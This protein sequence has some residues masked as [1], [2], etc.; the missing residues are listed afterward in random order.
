MIHPYSPGPSFA[1]I[2]SNSA[3]DLM[4]Q[5]ASITIPTT[6]T[7]L[8][9]PVV[10]VQRGNISYDNTTGI[11][12][13]NQ[14]QIWFHNFLVNTHAQNNRT[15]YAYA[16]INTGSGWV[17]S[18][19][20]GRIEPITANTDGQVPFHSNNYFAAGT[21]LRFWWY[22]SGASVTATSTDLP[23]LPAGTVTTPAVRIMYTGVN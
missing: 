19:W 16:E 3:L 10:A 18:R 12:T 4:D 6:P 21:K 22:T 13:F 15:V 5:S 8:I 2:L 17:I 14:S 7:I 9:L 1:S 20:S 23:S 11:I